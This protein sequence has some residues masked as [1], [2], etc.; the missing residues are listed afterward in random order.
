MPDLKQKF[1]NSILSNS[2]NYKY[3]RVSLSPIRYAGG[4]TLGVGHIIELLP[5]NISKIIS[6]FFGGGSVEIVMSQV[7]N[8][9]VI[10]FDIFNILTNYWNYQINE[11]EKLYKK[12]SKLE[13]DQETYNWVKNKLEDHWDKTTKTFDS[14]KKTCRRFKRYKNIKTDDIKSEWDNKKILNNLD[15]ATY[16]FFNF[17]LSYGPG[18]LGWAGKIYLN[19]KKYN[20]MLQ[21]VRNF[22][23]K[24]LQV[25]QGDFKYI[26]PQYK[27]EFLYC[28]P[29]YY[30]GEDSKMFKGIYPMRNIPIH[31]NGF[32]HELL[33]EMLKEHKGGFILSYNNCPKV[34]NWY[35]N[36]KQYFPEWQ[37]TM[38]QG[39]T[40]IGKYRENK[41]YIKESHEILIFSPP[42]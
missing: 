32:N 24:N 31:H 36:F 22:K 12:L 9:E 40:R 17:N 29:P 3:K 28:D 14:W 2:K 41:N 13:P 15:L 4:K 38:G 6:P 8:L 20:S 5:D 34:R 30:I 25:S 10:G 37:Y 7:L 23:P 39:E 33:A 1:L 16:Y 26:L 19:N 11:P 21:V 35:K 18:F 42:V 27:N